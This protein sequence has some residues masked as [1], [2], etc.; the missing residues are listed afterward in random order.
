MSKL[1]ERY[2]EIKKQKEAYKKKEKYKNF[3]LTEEEKKTLPPDVVDK[4][5]ENWRYL[6]GYQRSAQSLLEFEERRIINYFK[7]HKKFI[8]SLINDERLSTNKE[9]FFD[10]FTDQ[11]YI[12]DNLSDEQKVLYAE[13]LHWYVILNKGWL[14]ELLRD[15]YYTATYEYDVEDEVKEDKN[16]NKA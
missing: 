10:L 11:D 8:E 2:K 15:V 1:L 14:E 6:V 4:F 3:T 12:L 16:E 9:S 5:M 13:M 7:S